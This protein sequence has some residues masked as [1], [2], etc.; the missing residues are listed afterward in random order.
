MDSVIFSDSHHSLKSLNH[1]LIKCGGGYSIFNP[2][3][4]VLVERLKIM[5]RLRGNHSLYNRER[6]GLF[7]LRNSGSLCTRE[8]WKDKGDKGSSDIMGGWSF[9]VC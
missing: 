6:K 4:A 8:S 2:K 7:I 9:H 1:I 3:N 5:K